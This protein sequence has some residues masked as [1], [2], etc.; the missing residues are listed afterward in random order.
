[1]TQ[2]IQ[3]FNDF[4]E[5]EGGEGGTDSTTK[6]NTTHLFLCELSLIKN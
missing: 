6:F 1:M 4:W 5:V 3:N 2:K